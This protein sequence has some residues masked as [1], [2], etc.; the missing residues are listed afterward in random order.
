MAEI[1]DAVEA[2]IRRMK[3]ILHVE[4]DKG[5]EPFLARPGGNG[6]NA[7]ANIR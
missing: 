7:S 2:A 4:A 6:R 1:R 3:L 5:Q